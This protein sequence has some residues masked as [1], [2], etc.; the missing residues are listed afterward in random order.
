MR[1]H[2]NLA[3]AELHVDL[4]KWKDPSGGVEGMWLGTHVRSPKERRRD[5]RGLLG[6]AAAPQQSS[7]VDVHSEKLPK[8]P[9]SLEAFSN[10][11]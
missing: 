10:G 4:A 8:K 6:G 9:I 1:Y 3:E 7:L 5:W 11:T 2:K